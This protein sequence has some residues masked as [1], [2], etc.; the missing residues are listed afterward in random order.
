MTQ[1]ATDEAAVTVR[2]ESDRAVMEA[3][4]IKA[5][6]V[7]ACDMEETVTLPPGKTDSPSK[8]KGNLAIEITHNIAEF[9]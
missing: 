6:G 5:G 2:R 1:E 3:E 8:R 4:T 7:E 9:I